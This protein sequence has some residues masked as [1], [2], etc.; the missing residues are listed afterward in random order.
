MGH[1]DLGGKT[2]QYLIDGLYGGEDWGAAVPT[3]WQMR[4]FYD[5]WPSG[6][7]ASHDG[8]AI[9]SV[10]YD[11]I[12]AEWSLKNNG[13]RYLHEAAL[14]NNPP[15][16]TFYDPENDGTNLSSLGVHEH[17]N[18]ADGKQYSRNL[19]TGEGIEL[20]SSC[21]TCYYV[22]ILCFESFRFFLLRRALI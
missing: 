16:G 11:F 18:N 14:A 8:V 7:F 3:R 17:W 6:I 10:G 13:D 15:S 1:K 2:L 22:G 5:D 12:G 9:D 21:V 4:P 20:I 19:G